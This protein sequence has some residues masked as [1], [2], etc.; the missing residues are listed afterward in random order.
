MRITTNSTGMLA[1]LCLWTDPEGRESCVVVVKG[2]YGTNT[3]GDLE[4]TSEQQPLLYADEYYGDPETSCIR[5]ECDFAPEKPM[6]EVLVVGKAVPPS[7]ASV[8]KLQVRLEVMG[9][10]KEAMVF[11][12]RRWTRCL[13]GLASTE[14]LPF[15]E[16]PLTFDRAFGGIDDSRGPK[17][18][19]C[20]P[21][22]LVGV[23]FNPERSPSEMHGRPLPNI[24]HPA[25]LMQSHR[26]HPEPI[27]FGVLGR[28]WKQRVAFAGTYD[29]HWLDQQCPFLPEDFDTRYFMSAPSDQW[30]PHF[31]GG[32]LIR[33]THMAEEAMVQF[34]LPTVSVP[35]RYY[36]R[37]QIIEQQAVCD[38]VIVEPHAARVSILWR[39]RAAIG[40]RL[41][42]LKNVVVG[43]HPRSR[44]DD[45]HGYR[46]GKPHYRGLQAAIRWSTR[47]ERR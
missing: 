24:E 10:A 35:V 47:G 39:T 14:P 3:E 29:Q 36:F 20:E 25:Q 40:K 32:E 4:L 46:H 37:D 38:T 42:D 12:E 44:E 17:H 26:D 1:G 43:L 21:R 13:G 30:F 33:C 15:R 6:A 28:S 11:G 31:R 9:R 22:N 16:M 5:Y 23:G 8:Q 2:T 27:G 41:T 45:L 34:R 19:S 18:I 7:G